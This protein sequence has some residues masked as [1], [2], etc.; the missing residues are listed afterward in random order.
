M[1]TAR[2]PHARNATPR[3]T[4]TTPVTRG[5]PPSP[6]VDGTARETTM[7]KGNATGDIVSIGGELREHG[8]RARSRSGYG[9]EVPTLTGRGHGGG[10]PGSDRYSRS[11]SAARGSP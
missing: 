1:R 2:R 9:R 10:S 8:H 4:A 5:L 7:D 6:L 3:V 11:P